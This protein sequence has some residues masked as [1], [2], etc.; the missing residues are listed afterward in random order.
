MKK[1]SEFQMKLRR[2]NSQIKG[3]AKMQFEFL[4]ISPSYELANQILKNNKEIDLEQLAKLV[5]DLYKPKKTYELEKSEKSEVLKE[6]LKVIELRTMLGDL[7]NVNFDDWWKSIG[8]WYYGFDHA[9]PSVELISI[10]ERNQISFEKQ[11]LIHR[12]TNYVDEK[13][14]SEGNPKTILVSIPIGI[15]KK[16]IF[17]QINKLIDK[18]NISEI[19]KARNHNP[20]VLKRFRIDALT[21]AIYLLKSWA[22]LEE[23]IQ[24]WRFAVITGISPTIAEGLNFDSKPTNINLDQRNTLAVLMHRSL[25]QA[26]YIAENAAHGIFPSREKCRLPQFDQA[27]VFARLNAMR[28]FEKQA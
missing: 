25:T 13:R 19:T 10:F 8:G 23:P 22:A 17:D 21:N 26:Q 12:L 1:K 20:F 3:I 18:H 24:L 4:R 14:K 6:F 27:K 28:N 11:D 9:E 5:T 2:N 15:N 16:Q 7:T